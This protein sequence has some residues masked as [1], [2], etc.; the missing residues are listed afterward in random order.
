MFFAKQ[1]GHVP[2]NLY[3]P[4]KTGIIIIIWL[5]IIKIFFVFNKEKRT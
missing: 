4:Y 3:E 1:V 2:I 5:E